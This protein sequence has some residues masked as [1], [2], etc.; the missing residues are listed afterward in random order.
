MTSNP[1]IFEK[2][3]VGS[4]EY[5]KDIQAMALEGKDVKAIYETLSQRD[6]QRAADEFRSVYD[7]SDGHDGYV[8]LEV[9]PHLAH[10][11]NGTVEEAHRL[12][13]A[14]ARPNVFI[15]IP[16]TTEG[17]SAIQELISEGIKARV[18]SMPSWELFER[19]SRDYRDSVIPPE[20]TARV[21]VEQASTFGWTHYT[22]RAGAVIGMKTFGASAPLK[23]LQR[24]FGFTPEQIV[25]AARAQVA[26]AQGLPSGVG[27]K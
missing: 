2:A 6:V 12:W 17:L 18:V 13:K 25:A 20:V 9:T 24:K 14:L 26:R 3:I 7:T 15:K 5:D 8:S 1:S 4:H 10:D 27:R 19:Q 23:E 11:T 16:A 22:G 21:A